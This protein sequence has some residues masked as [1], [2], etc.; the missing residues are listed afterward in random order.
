V[1]QHNGY[2]NVYS[3]P[4]RGTK[5]SI[6]LPIVKE[7]EVMQT[8]KE[9]ATPPGGIETILLAE[10]DPAVS[11]FHKTLLEAAGYTVIAVVD[12]EEALHTF[13]EYEKDIDL[14]ILD[15]IMPKMNGKEAYDLIRKVKPGVK[16]MFLSGYPADS[17]KDVEIVQERER[18]L[19]KPVDPNDLLMKVRE[20]LSGE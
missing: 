17:L 16:A 8:I 14:L 3:E 6:Y 2:V 13:K 11:D 7:K 10:D 4:D 18:F 15:V 9:S 20:V 1:K 19:A 5:F 12:G